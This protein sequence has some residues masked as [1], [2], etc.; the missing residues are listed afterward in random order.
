MAT[1]DDLDK[2]IAV[3]QE[4]MK[5]LKKRRVELEQKRHLEDLEAFMAWAKAYELTASDN[6]RIT[7]FDL[8]SRTK[9]GE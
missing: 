6:K 2:Q 1:I 7:V 9:D 4:R 8:Y 3:A 5:K